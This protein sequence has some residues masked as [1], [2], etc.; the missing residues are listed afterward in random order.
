VRCCTIG[1]S[2][3]WYG[4]VANPICRF[5]CLSVSPEDVL[6][7][8]V[9]DKSADCVWM[10]FGVEGWRSSKGK[11]LSWGK[12]GAS[13]CNLW[14]LW[15]SYSRLRGCDAALPRLLWDYLIIFILRFGFYLSFFVHN[16]YS[17]DAD[18]PVICSNL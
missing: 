9:N 3:S 4:A 2:G 8:V 16:S 14:G 5:V 12:C 6:C 13:R 1:V 15:R 18:K 10:P 11:V 17:S 7:T